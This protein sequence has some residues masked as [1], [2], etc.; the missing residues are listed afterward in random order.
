MVTESTMQKRE[1]ASDHPE[2]MRGGR[3][4]VPHVDIVER[5][6]RLVVLADMPG[7]KAGDVTIDYERGMLTIHGNVTPRQNPEQT[8]FMLQEYG[9][10]DYYRS[11]HSGE[12]IDDTRI[13]AQMSDGVLTLTLP[14]SPDVMPRR[15]SVKT[16]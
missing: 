8:H 6:D 2:R 16:T 5:E 12:G 7:V 14:K 10:G 13:E 15:I 11:F 1:T 3:A 9:V 4:F